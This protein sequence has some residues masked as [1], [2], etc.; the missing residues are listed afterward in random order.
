MRLVHF[1]T[2]V[3]G[4]WVG[5]MIFLSHTFGHFPINIKKEENWC[6]FL[7]VDFY[8]LNGYSFSCAYH[9][10]YFHSYGFLT[11]FFFSFEM[12]SCMCSGFKSN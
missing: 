10:K 3:R 2:K 1:G 12:E 8:V 9:V 5:A 11:L 6:H 7:L 4:N